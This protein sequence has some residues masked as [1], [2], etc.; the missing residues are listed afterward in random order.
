[1]LEAG[2]WT[3]WE[4]AADRQRPDLPDDAIVLVKFRD[5]LLSRGRR[6]DMLRWGHDNVSDDIVAYRVIA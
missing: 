2:E 6:A 1:M 5:G 3:D 4:P